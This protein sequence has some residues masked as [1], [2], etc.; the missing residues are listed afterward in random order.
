MVLSPSRRWEVPGLVAQLRS[1]HP[2]CRGHT[3]CNGRELP[4]GLVVRIWSF[5]CC[6]P[7]LLPRL[8]TKIS[9]QA[10]A[11]RAPHPQKD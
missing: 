1:N 5:R 8:G 9:H 10:T 4:G 2:V 11:H 7:G 3:T 6:G